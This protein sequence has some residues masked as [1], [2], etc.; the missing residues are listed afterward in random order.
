MLVWAVAV[1][2]VKRD[3]R[4]GGIGRYWSGPRFM[5][6]RILVLLI[7]V[8]LT[9][10]VFTG[11]ARYSGIHPLILQQLFNPPLVISWIGAVL[12][13]LGVAFAVWARINIGS[14]WS[15]MPAVKEDHELVTTGP[16][17][18]VRHPIYTGMLLAALGTGLTGVIFGVLV[19]IF[20]LIIFNWRISVEERLMLQVFPDKYPVYKERTKR[21][22]P[23]VW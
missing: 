14:N 15:G 6:F 8:Y 19:F 21:L 11:S 1:I 12:A 10:R 3:A 22:I 13:V 9:V 5:L 7:V 20:A 16:Y 17:A 4:G 23:F 2:W 18:Y